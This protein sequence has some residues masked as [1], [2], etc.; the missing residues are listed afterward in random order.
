MHSRVD[1][2]ILTDGNT[3]SSNLN[4]HSLGIQILNCTIT[5][6]NEKTR[7]RVD[8]KGASLVI[9]QNK[10]MQ[11]W[12]LVNESSLNIVKVATVAPDAVIG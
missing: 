10:S 6:I 8:T 11:N 1:F 3:V 7:L 5:K 12:F 4:K 2:D 9:Y